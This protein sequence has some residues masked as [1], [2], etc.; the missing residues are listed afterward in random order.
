MG[1]VNQNN[2]SAFIDQSSEDQRKLRKI[3]HYLLVVCKFT[4][5]QR[6]QQMQV[7]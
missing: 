3:G 6:Q 4:L 2:I 1:E 5:K 7:L